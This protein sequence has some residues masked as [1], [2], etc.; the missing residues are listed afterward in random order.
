M[1]NAYSAQKINA[2]LF[3]SPALL[4]YSIFLLYPMVASLALSFT[5]WDGISSNWSFAG[6]DN[7]RHIL[8]DDPQSRRAVTNNVIW[9]AVTVLVPVSLGLVLAT[10]LNESLRGRTFFRAVFYSPSV[11]PLV[12]VALIWAWIYNPHFGLVN[13]SLSA[14]GLGSLRHGWLSEF[15]TALPATLVT[16]IWHGSGFPMLLYLAGLQ[17]IPRQQYEAAEMDGAG[18]FR[19]FFHITL[20]LLF[21]THIVVFSLTAMQSLR[22][23]DLIYTMTYGGPGRSTHVLSTWMY[24]NLF[25]YRQAGLGSALAWI[26]VAVSL[27][28]TVPYMRMVSRSRRA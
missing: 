21:E 5:H 22:A 14:I 6:L 2:W 28:V 19:R 27:I 17:S 13:M 20:P 9:T 8:W 12:A 4:V 3:L 16:A 15:S 26:I 24:F 25:Q 23:F 18:W 1:N 10:L 11:L 7:Y